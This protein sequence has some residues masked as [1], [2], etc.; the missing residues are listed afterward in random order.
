MLSW[1][2]ATEIFCTPNG[3]RFGRINPERGKMAHFLAT[4]AGRAMMNRK[5][6]PTHDYIL[7]LTG[8]ERPR[9]LFVGTA[10]G[11]DDDYAL[12]FFDTYDS[13]RCAPQRLALFHRTV[14]DLESY[15]REFDV[16][17]VGG[18]N[19]ANMLDV[20]NRQGLDSILRDIWEDRSSNTVLTGGSA[21]GLCWF[22]GSTTDSY[23]PT[24]Q[25]FP[26]GLSL[27]SASFCPHYDAED[28]RRPLF[29]QGL[30]SG[31]LP[32]GYA[33]GNLQSV[34]FDGPDFIT[35]ISPV[36]DGLALHVEAVDGQIVESP[37]P[38]ITPP[39]QTT[40]STEAN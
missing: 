3:R 12:S 39:R 37:L 10:S 32:Q 31:E 16:I 28:Q 27:I 23:G 14:D 36:K 19:T 13:F 38:I 30:L 25:L 7:R 8:K 17:H 1:A 5:D 4:G 34:H 29:H 21:G 2:G 40:R 6:D 26:E 11:D 9:V 22:A 20:W 15:V 18:G 24:L 35:A 33:V